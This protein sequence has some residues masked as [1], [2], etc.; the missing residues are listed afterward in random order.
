MQSAKEMT[1]IVLGMRPSPLLWYRVK[2]DDKQEL[3]AIY[4][5]NL[6]RVR[7]DHMVVRHPPGGRVIFQRLSSIRFL[8]LWRCWGTDGV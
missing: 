1:E 2:E 8:H 6:L 7:K 4:N 3:Q 5:E